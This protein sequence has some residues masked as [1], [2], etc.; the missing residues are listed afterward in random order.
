ME[1]IF[2]NELVV[3]AFTIAIYFLAQKLQEKTRII[4]LNPILV[5]VIII[6]LFLMVFH[7]DYETYHQGSRYIDFFLR[8]AVVALGV[9]LYKQLEKIKKQA[10][11]IIIS[12]LIGCIAGIVSVVLIARM[13]GA[14][15]EIIYSL[16]P[17]SVTTPIAIEVSKTI[18]GIPALTASV[19]IV[20]GIFGAIFGYS[21]MKLTKVK[22]PI[23]QSLSMGNAAHAVGTSR[24]MQISPNFGA[25]SSIGLIVNGIFTAILSP[26]ILKLLAMWIKF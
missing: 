25:M 9:P 10:L 16:A 17:K 7:I 13:M 24:S 22:N 23:A 4:L 18:G 12:Q 1:E 21:I 19:V 15:R 14:P 26:Y 8:P 6:I 3:V 20:V 5:T 11:N 2:Q